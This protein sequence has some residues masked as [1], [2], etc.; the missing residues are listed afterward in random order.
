MTSFSSPSS[1][2]FLCFYF[3]NRNTSCLYSLSLVS[4]LYAF[5]SSFMNHQNFQNKVNNTDFYICKPKGQFSILPSLGLK[6]RSGIWSCCHFLFLE[7]AISV[8]WSF[9][10][11]MLLVSVLRSLLYLLMTPT[12]ML[13]AICMM[14]PATHMSSLDAL[15]SNLALHPTAYLTTLIYTHR[16]LKLKF[17]IF[18]MK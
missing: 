7:I 8:Y 2:L 16:L 13:S 10:S 5:Q 17:Q 11:G 12:L 1:S 6:N 4:L 15:N 9:L 14:N 3:L 18:F